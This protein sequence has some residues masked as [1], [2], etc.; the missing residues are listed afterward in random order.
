MQECLAFIPKMNLID[1]GAQKMQRNK[2]RI[3][4]ELNMNNSNE[5]LLAGL[6]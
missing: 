2:Y 4:G 5:N 6:R 3:R 1:V